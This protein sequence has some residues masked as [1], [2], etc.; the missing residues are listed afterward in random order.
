MKIK[1]KLDFLRKNYQKAKLETEITAGIEGM[2]AL[3]DAGESE[4]MALSDVFE[5]QDENDVVVYYNYVVK[6]MTNGS[7]KPVSKPKNGRLLSSKNK[8][9]SKAAGMSVA[10]PADKPKAAA[11]PKATTKPKAAPKPKPAA[12]PKAAPKAKATDKDKEAAKMKANEMKAE[13]G[14]AKMQ[15]DI[16]ALETSVKKKKALVVANSSFKARL[17]KEM[18]DYFKTHG[19]VFEERK[20]VNGR[21]VQAGGAVRLAGGLGRL[22]EPMPE[23]E[24]AR[25]KVQDKFYGGL[26]AGDLQDFAA[27]SKRI[28]L[29]FRTAAVRRKKK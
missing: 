13:K 8:S 19:M 21:V 20:V 16:K 6:T 18:A 3:A 15:A 23:V 17:S 22:P 12:K 14:R 7:S 10:K 11:K 5:P 4:G 28:G 27:V 29:S 9:K 2:L 24:L 26:I 25:L 1:E